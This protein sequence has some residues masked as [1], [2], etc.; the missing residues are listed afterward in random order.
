M[1]NPFQPVFASAELACNVGGDAL[2]RDCPCRVSSKIC[3]AESEGTPPSLTYE[4]F[5]SGAD[6]QLLLSY[7]AKVAALPYMEQLCHT[8][9]RVWGT[10]GC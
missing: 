3:M 6:D 5:L 4:E 8:A 10:H 9:G 2:R 1:Q 7:P